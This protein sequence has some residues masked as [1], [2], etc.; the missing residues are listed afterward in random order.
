MAGQGISL[1]PEGQI[2]VKNISDKPIDDLALTVAFYD[3]TVKRNMGVISVPVASPASEPLAPGTK[4]TL[5]F[6]SPNIA[7]SDHHLAVIIYFNGRLLKELP[8][9]KQR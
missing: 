1:T 6:S 5:Y 9:V 4:R 3:N 8:V 2:V 7:N